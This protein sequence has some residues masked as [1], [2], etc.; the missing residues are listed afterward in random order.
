M[1][2]SL[3]AGFLRLDH[4]RVPRSHMLARFARVTPEGVY[5]RVP[6]SHAKAAF[7]TM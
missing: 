5:E 7:G 1:C 4:V 3:C 6:G 2:V